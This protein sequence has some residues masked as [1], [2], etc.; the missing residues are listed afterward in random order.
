MIPVDIDN[1]MIYNLST[2]NGDYCV[3]VRDINII[4]KEISNCIKLTHLSIANSKI[5]DISALS[6]CTELTVLN[7]ARNKIVDISALSNCTK[8]TTLVLNNNKIIDI[9]ILSK[10]ILIKQLFVMENCINARPM[11]N[12]SIAIY[13]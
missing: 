13:Y 6:N 12:Q 3:Y 1:F 7:L 5:V 4:P 8:L 2:Y 11:F 9:S 10:C